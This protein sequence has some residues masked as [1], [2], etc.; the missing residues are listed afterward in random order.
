MERS[1]FLKLFAAGSVVS[2]FSPLELLA[3]EHKNFKDIF[4]NSYETKKI[5]SNALYFAQ[6]VKSSN[7]NFRVDVEYFAR[8]E[9]KKLN[10]L[11]MLYTFSN[12]KGFPVW[13]RKNEGGLD[14]DGLLYMDRVVDVDVARKPRSEEE[15][16]VYSEYLHNIAMIK[17]SYEQMIN[18][19]K[20]VAGRFFDG[21]N[22]SFERLKLH[23]DLGRV[24]RNYN[25]IPH[26]VVI[27]GNMVPMIERTFSREFFK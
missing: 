12:A 10:K 16:A 27:N 1:E 11:D 14:S 18:K 19:D 21:L 7:A 8:A 15:F 20:K 13:L 17:V 5:F 9:E 22:A 23:G 2:I 24:K 6:N 4:G 3:S 25:P 26:R